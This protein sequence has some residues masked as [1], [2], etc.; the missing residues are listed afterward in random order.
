MVTF[1]YRC[2]YATEG[3]I[4]MQVFNFVVLSVVIAPHNVPLPHINKTHFPVVSR[5]I[6]ELKLN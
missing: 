4:G 3:H 1:C 5:N 6:R 2:N